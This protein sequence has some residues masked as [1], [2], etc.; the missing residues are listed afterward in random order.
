[1][2]TESSKPAT[3]SSQNWLNIVLGAAVPFIPGVKDWIAAHPQEYIGI[4][5]AINVLWR[6]FVTK[7]PVEGIW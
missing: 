5:A 1:M 2:G 4:L 7:K 3:Q 6:T